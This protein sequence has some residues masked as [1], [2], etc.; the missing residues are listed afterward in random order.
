MKITQCKHLS[1]PSYLIISRIH[2]CSSS[3]PS[4]I[5]AKLRKLL[6]ENVLI[7]VH[8]VAICLIILATN[9]YFFDKAK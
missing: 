7:L 2:L 4:E 8:N 3:S 9:P 1:L 6:K 5:N